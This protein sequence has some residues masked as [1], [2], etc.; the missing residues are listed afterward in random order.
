MSCG[1][2]CTVSLSH[3]V[4]SWSLV[5]DCG[6]SWAYLVFFKPA[7]QHPQSLPFSLLIVERNP[8]TELT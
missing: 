1:C 8:V 7:D 6:I 5:C 4:V 2:L 3:G